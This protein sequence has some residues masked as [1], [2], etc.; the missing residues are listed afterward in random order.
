M[1]IRLAGN[2]AD[3]KGTGYRGLTVCIQY[4]QLL[5]AWSIITDNNGVLTCTI[6][7]VPIQ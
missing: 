6:A 3:G 7:L 2:D 5:A 4:T 1:Q